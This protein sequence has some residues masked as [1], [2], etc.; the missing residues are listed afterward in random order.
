ME[1]PRKFIIACEAFD[2]L[3]RIFIWAN[4]TNNALSA[5]M[6]LR[7][8]GSKALKDIYAYLFLYRVRKVYQIAEQIIHEVC[9]QIIPIFSCTCS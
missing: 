5:L 2:P 9:F 3:A 6:K 1:T 7:A 4:D 8:Y